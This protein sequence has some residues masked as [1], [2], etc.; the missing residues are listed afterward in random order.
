MKKG[1]LTVLSA[2]MLI[3]MVGCSSG[4]TS[5]KVDL[6]VSEAA[7][8]TYVYDAA[9]DGFESIYSNVLTPQY[10]VFA[11]MKTEEE[12]DFFTSTVF[13]VSQSLLSGAVNPLT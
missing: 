12:A 13:P 4:E 9:A 11:G 10:Y 6:T 8:N 1:F 2:S 7:A 3:G 5:N